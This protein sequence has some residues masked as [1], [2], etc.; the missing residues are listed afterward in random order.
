MTKLSQARRRAAR[1]NGANS[2]GP[3]TPE[4][5]AR[6][7]LNAVRHGLLSSRTHLRDVEIALADGLRQTYASRYLPQDQLEF[8]VIETLVMLQIKLRRVDRLEMEAID[9]VLMPRDGSGGDVHGA[10]NSSDEGSADQKKYPSLATLMRYR[11]GLNRERHAAEAR[12]V[13]LIAE[14][15]AADSRRGT[16]TA[17]WMPGHMQLGVALGSEPANDAGD[18]NEPGGSDPGAERSQPSDK[19]SAGL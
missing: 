18:M 19:S 3:V 7:S 2:R 8:E 14:R 13:Q 5:K 17:E 11:S 4:G 16:A 6:S 1:I 15:P 9:R 10:L 12:L